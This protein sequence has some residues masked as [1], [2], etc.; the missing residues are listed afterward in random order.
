M[1]GRY[2]P[3]ERDVKG[4]KAF[5]ALKTGSAVRDNVSGPL[6]LPGKMSETLICCC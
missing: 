2:G 4:E 5:L 1:A 6:V 3:A